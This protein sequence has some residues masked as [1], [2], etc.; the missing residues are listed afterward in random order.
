MSE[1][2]CELPIE[3]M[4]S[5]VSGTTTIPVGERVVRCGRCVFFLRGHPGEDISW[6]RHLQRMVRKDGFCSFGRERDGND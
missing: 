3:G 5:F 4:R 1:Y 6:C 2:V